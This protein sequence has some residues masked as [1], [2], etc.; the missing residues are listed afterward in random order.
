MT[1]QKK[2]ALLRSAASAL[3]HGRHATAKRK[4]QEIKREGQ[5]PS[6]QAENVATILAALRFAMRAQTLLDAA[7]AKAEWEKAHTP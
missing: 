4:L 5:Y 3:E 1:N 2:A 6:E 7:I